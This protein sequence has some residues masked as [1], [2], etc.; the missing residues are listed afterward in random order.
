MPDGFFVGIQRRFRRFSGAKSRN[1]CED[2]DKKGAGR[3]AGKLI[4][5]SYID[6]PVI[7]TCSGFPCLATTQII[8]TFDIERF[9]HYIQH[10]NTSLQEHRNTEPLI[11]SPAHLPAPFLPLSSHR[12]LDLAPLNLRNLCWIPTK[13]SIWHLTDSFNQCFLKTWE[14]TS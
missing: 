2:N 3:W 11:N 14:I 5:G 9:W 10:E 4:R 6:V 12:F 13:K 1:L 8:Q 7:R